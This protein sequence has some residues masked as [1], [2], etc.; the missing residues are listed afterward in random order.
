MRWIIAHTIGFEVLIIS[1]I[2]V[3]QEKFNFEYSIFFSY[4][5]IGSSEMKSSKH[6]IGK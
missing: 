6:H 5:K 1:S 3:R 2:K 4:L